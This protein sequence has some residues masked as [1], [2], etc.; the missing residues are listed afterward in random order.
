MLVLEYEA[1]KLQMRED[2]HHQADKPGAS[3]L[4]L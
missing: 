4:E 1:E 2:Y 3:L